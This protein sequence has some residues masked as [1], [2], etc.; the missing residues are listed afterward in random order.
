MKH[1][2]IIL[3][4][5]AAP[6]LSA[7]TIYDIGEQL[8]NSSRE[9]AR[10]VAV[11]NQEADVLKT[12]SHAQ[13][14]LDEMQPANSIDKAIEIID[15]FMARSA[16]F[17]PPLS[18]EMQRLLNLARQPLADA[19]LSPGSADIKKLREDLHHNVIHQLQKRMGSNA[20]ALDRVLKQYQ[21]MANLTQTALL[22][23]AL[24]ASDGAGR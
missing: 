23:S 4:S 22:T 3:L 7:Q 21:A 20:L 10:A 18:L 17:G 13:Q 19:K 6:A 1:A 16:R 14:T 5:L 24:A 9:L 2:L 11:V 15:D 8:N 12:V